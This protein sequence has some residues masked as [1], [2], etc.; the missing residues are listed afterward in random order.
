MVCLHWNFITLSKLRLAYLLKQ[1]WTVPTPVQSPAPQLIT[2]ENA[3]AQYLLQAQS[4]WICHGTHSCAAQS[5]IFSEVKWSLIRTQLPSV[6]TIFFLVQFIFS[7]P[8]LD[9]PL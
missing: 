4:Y 1:A 5:Y 6:G 7:E 9:I 2:K 3:L 8:S